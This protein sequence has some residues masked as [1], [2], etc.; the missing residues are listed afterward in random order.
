VIAIPA[1]DLRAGAAVRLA[2]GEYSREQL[3]IGDPL[4][5]AR[6]W[7]RIG[8]RQLHI[9]DLDAAFGIGAN[10]QVIIDVL[11]STRMDVQVGGGIRTDDHIE[12]LLERGARRVVVGTQALED[13]EWLD[14]VAA[15]FPH[16]LIVAADV[17]DRRIV[18]RG[19]LRT[20]PADIIETVHELNGLPL[21][22][23]LVTA[24]H[25]QGLQ[26]GTD[27]ALMEDVAGAASI[28]VYAA[29]GIASLDDLRAL[30]DRGVSAAIVGLALYSGAIDPRAAAG[31]F[32]E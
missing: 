24:V 16:E 17:R 1:L 25:R 10:D 31:E 3:R 23:V 20:L 28:P 2:G 30:S 4:G 22:G 14:D 26:R 11:A 19:W 12:R 15:R 7:E 21:A 18:T 9:V 6:M 27:L 13:T 32:E 29:G 5:V 8:F